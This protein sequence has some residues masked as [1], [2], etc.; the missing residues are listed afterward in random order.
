VASDVPL[1]SDDRILE[2]YGTQIDEFPPQGNTRIVLRI[3]TTEYDRKCPR[4][5]LLRRVTKLQRLLH[6]VEISS[7]GRVK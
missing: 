5:D 6:T 1:S 3:P 2:F 4:T 7:G